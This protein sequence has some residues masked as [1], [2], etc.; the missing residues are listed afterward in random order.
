MR[1]IASGFID[2]LRV[3]AM[4]AALS[5]LEMFFVSTTAD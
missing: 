4:L 1:I 3:R 2:L 5:S